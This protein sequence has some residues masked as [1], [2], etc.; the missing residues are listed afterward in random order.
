MITVLYR[1]LNFSVYISI[2]TTSNGEKLF[3]SS[4]PIKTKEVMSLLYISILTFIVAAVATPN[5]SRFVFGPMYGWRYPL[6]QSHIE[7]AE[8]TLCPG[9][10]PSPEITRAS[11]WLGMEAPNN[12]GPQKTDLIQAI[13]VSDPGLFRRYATPRSYSISL[14]NAENVKPRRDSGAY[15][16]VS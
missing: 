8:T 12:R 9:K 13:I 4:W 5:Q 2:K 6:V 11:M 16:L 7:F 14:I 3:F 1:A 15:S 10:P